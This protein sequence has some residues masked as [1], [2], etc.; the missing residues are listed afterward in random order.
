MQTAANCHP[1]LGH[2]VALEEHVSVAEILP[3]LF[4]GCGQGRGAGDVEAE[5]CGGD[6]LSGWLL[7]FLWEVWEGGEEFVVDCWDGC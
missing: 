1:D 6:R 2:A 7:G 5:V 3:G 4:G